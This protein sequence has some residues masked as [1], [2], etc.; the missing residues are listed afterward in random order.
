MSC[1][2]ECIHSFTQED[3]ML[4]AVLAISIGAIAFVYSAIAS[5][6][7]KQK[8]I[9]HAQIVKDANNSVSNKYS[10]GSNYVGCSRRFVVGETPKH[11]VVDCMKVDGIYHKVPESTSSHRTKYHFYE[12]YRYGGTTFYF[13][14]SILDSISQY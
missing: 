14:D 7:Q 9:T 3:T 12:T 10:Y 5:E 4:Q 6:T 11:F 2:N 13:R 1:Y 8:E